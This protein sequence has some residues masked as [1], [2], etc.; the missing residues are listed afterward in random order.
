MHDN[1]EWNERLVVAFSPDYHKTQVAAFEKHLSE[2]TTILGDLTLVKQGKTPIKTQD[3]LETKIQEVLK[4][5]KTADFFDIS[6]TAT[7]TKVKIRKYGD[8]PARTEDKIAF[9]LQITEKTAE[10]AAHKAVLGW[11][12]Y[13]T[14]APAAKLSVEKVITTYKAEF[15]VEYRFNQLHNKTAPL[16][17]IFLHKDN[18]IVALIRFLTLGIKVL[19]IMEYNIRKKI[20]DEKITVSHIYPGNPSRKTDKPTIEMILRALRNISLVIITLNDTPVHVHVSTLSKHQQLF[21]RLA[22]FNDDIYTNITQFLK[23]TA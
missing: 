6:I 19:G 10:I 5:H 3:E 23:S 22:G 18:R 1:Y 15:N 12:A 14:N 16:M 9:A 13:V 2:T 8:K 21:I 4:A 20:A 7:V 17:P 11:R